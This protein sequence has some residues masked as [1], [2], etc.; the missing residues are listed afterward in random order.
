MAIKGVIFDI[1]KY[2]IHD[3]PG[4]RTTVFLKGCPLTCAW[5][6][7]PESQQIEPERTSSVSRRR[8]S[9]FFFSGEKNVIGRKVSVKQ[10]MDEVEKDRIFYQYS[11][12]GV[13]FSGGEPLMQPAFLLELLK[14]SQR[15]K[16]H[17]ALD[18][19]GFAEWTEIKRMVRYVDLFLY[20]LKI[21]DETLHKRYTGQSNT[22]ILDNLKRLSTGNGEIIIRFPV[23]SGITDTSDNL[24]AIGKFVRGLKRVEKLHLLPYNYMCKDK[25]R[26]M[27]RSYRF[28]GI[29]P[30]SDRE[31]KRMK[32]RFE[33]YGLQVGIRG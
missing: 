25:Y 19:S 27:R 1:V 7:N 13:T 29:E 23:I 24:R 11:Q 26:R 22:R 28:K 3:G 12:G 6:Q 18:T 16:I 32:M 17:T 30:P 20:D 21:M 10:V 14:E 4:I 15:R 8:Y 33:K 9:Q 5:C 2:A 31:L